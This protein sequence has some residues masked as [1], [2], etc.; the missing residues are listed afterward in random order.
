MIRT[1]RRFFA[2]ALLLLL[3]GTASAG[4]QALLPVVTASVG[5][6]DQGVRRATKLSPEVQLSHVFFVDDEAGLA[7]GAGVFWGFWAGTNTTS[8]EDCEIYS[9]FTH[10]VGARVRL[11]PSTR[12]MGPAFEV[13][14]ARRF[15]RATYE[16]GSTGR[17][18]PRGDY[19]TAYPAADAGLD[20]T[21]PL[22]PRLSVGVGARGNVP[23]VFGED[24]GGDVQF[25]IR[26]V[27]NAIARYRL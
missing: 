18:D 6:S 21:V 16:R 27:G 25:G 14:I 23:L 4:A 2:S 24:V 8:C 15:V 1:S 20:L 12:R 3:I 7:V 17:G 26:F 22:S 9:Y 11:S 19:W 13:G 5:A 10:T